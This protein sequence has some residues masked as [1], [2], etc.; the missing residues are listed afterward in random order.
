MNNNHKYENYKG[1]FLTKL[2]INLVPD[3]LGCEG[4]SRARLRVSVRR[5]HLKHAVHPF[6]LED[7]P[8][9]FL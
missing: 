9:I 4:D 5:S 2:R 7:A 8:E 1:A 3:S 6:D